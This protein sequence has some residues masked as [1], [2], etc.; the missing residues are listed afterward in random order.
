MAGYIKHGK[1]FISFR[2]RSD[3]QG[4]KCLNN[5]VYKQMFCLHMELFKIGDRLALSMCIK[6]NFVPRHMINLPIMVF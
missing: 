3:N 6:M 5:F 1:T 2:D 4:K